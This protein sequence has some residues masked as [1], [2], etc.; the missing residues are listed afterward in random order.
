MARGPRRTHGIIP[1]VRDD[2]R[3]FGQQQYRLRYLALQRARHQVGDETGH[4]QHQRCNDAVQAQLVGDRLGIGFE[5]KGTQPPA[6][7]T[8]G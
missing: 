8:T 5:I 1:P 6:I 3:R 2:P 7:L 4:R